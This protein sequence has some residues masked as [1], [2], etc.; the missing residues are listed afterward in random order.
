LSVTTIRLFSVGIVV[1]FLGAVLVVFAILMHSRGLWALGLG[2]MAAAVLLGSVGYVRGE[3]RRG[4]GLTTGSAL[5]GV[6]FAVWLV[7]WTQTRPT[8]WA[9]VVTLLFAMAGLAL[10]WLWW[11]HERN[12]NPSDQSH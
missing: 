1:G 5:W 8:S 7:V 4:R 10:A 3:D 2:A 11:R 6:S 12:G 9:V